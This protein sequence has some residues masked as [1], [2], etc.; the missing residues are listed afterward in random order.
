MTPGIT[1]LL[2]GLLGWLVWTH[3]RAGR[4]FDRPAIARNRLFDPLLVTV[5]AVLA[6]AGLLMLWLARPAAAIAATALLV[7][8][9]A[10]RSTIRT[11]TFQRWLLR[12]DFLA[13]RRLHP[14][15]PER[16]LLARLVVRRHP[17]WGEE[18]AEQMVIDYPSVDEIA[19]MLARMER[20]F[21]GFR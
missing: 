8:L 3:V 5:S 4:Y 1:A 15:L 18:L 10:Y 7:A 13:L 17:G 20:G 6:A 2:L 16:V 9:W 19:A 21:R 12:R 14:D 11:V